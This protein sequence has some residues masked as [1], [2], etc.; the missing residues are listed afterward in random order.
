[1]GYS[2]FISSTMGNKSLVFS[3]GA[4]VVEALSVSEEFYADF[5]IPALRV[6]TV[7]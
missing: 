6:M 5:N 1:M 4:S 2:G 3:L 7:L